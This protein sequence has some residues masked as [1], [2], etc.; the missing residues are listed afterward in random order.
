MPTRVLISTMDNRTSFSNNIRENSIDFNT[1]QDG[2][3]VYLPVRCNIKVTLG[4]QSVTSPN[5]N[6]LGHPTFF[7]FAILRP[8]PK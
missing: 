2:D 3:Q 6:I 8:T 4:V 7:L 5:N 1:K